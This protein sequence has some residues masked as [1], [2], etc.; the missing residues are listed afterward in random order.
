VTEPRFD[1]YTV[2]VTD[3]IRLA[4]LKI[5]ENKH[6]AVVVLNGD[7]VVGTVSDGDIR[8]AFLDEVLPAAPV[9]E[10]MNINCVTTTETDRS[11]AYQVL[12]ERR[13]TVLPVVTADGRLVDIVTAYEP[14]AGPDAPHAAR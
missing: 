3:P 7:R 12:L 5:T 8:R 6:R 11:R 10:I 1:V 2:K 14:F 9:T 4:M 13:V